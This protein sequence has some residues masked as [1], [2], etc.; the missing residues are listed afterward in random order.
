M[1][2]TLKYMDIVDWTKEQIAVGAFQPRKKFFSE[3]KLGEIFGYSRQT[4]RRALEELEQMGYITRIKGSGTYISESLP[5]SGNQPFVHETASKVIGVISTHLD[6]YIFP[7]II[8]GIENVLNTDGYTTLLTS[9]KNLVE[10]EIRALQIMQER[11]LDGLIVEPTKSGLPCINL[12]FYQR[13][14]ERGIPIVFI[15]SFYPEL[16]APY[17]SLDDE[18]AGYAAV[19]HL[20][21]MGHRDIA[22]IFTHSDRQGHLRYKGYVRALTEQGMPIRDDHIFWY[23]KE[24]MLQILYSTELWD[25]LTDCTAAL[26]YNDSLAIMLINL[27]RQKG[28]RVPE[29]FSVVGIDNSELAETNS[30]TSIIHPAKELG[31]AAANLL[32]SMIKGAEGKNI[33]F[34]PQLVTRGTVKKMEIKNGTDQ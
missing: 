9:T 21:S 3:N 18:E 34:P 7:T 6:A 10:G 14:A 25:G 23:S 5:T 19:K 31:E 16:S 33:L 2:N 13:I 26:C 8:Q 27:I 24:N 28:K 17:V 4:V 29:D 20:L 30:L 1:Y 11:P 22:G 12:D 15:D 32:L